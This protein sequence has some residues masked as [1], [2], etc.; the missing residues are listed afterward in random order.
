MKKDASK[1]KG[2]A[3]GGK[4]KLSPAEAV[5]R[6]QQSRKAKELHRLEKEGAHPVTADGPSPTPKGLKRTAVHLREAV[7]T[8]LPPEQRQ[9]AICISC[10][11]PMA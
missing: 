1:G 4:A 7:H 2:K 8:K 10:M 9:I 5:R 11:Q 3:K 6:Q